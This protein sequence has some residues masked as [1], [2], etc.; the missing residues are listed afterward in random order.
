VAKRRAGETRAPDE[1]TEQELEQADG[2]ALPERQAL[3]L[4]HGA[5]PL[6][7]PILPHETTIPIEPDTT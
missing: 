7:L 4:I 5:E 6:P 3:T 1:L 2:E